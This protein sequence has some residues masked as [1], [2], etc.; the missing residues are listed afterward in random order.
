[1]TTSTTAGSRFSSYGD[2][3]GG[4]HNLLHGVPGAR[5]VGGWSA[6]LSSIKNPENEAEVPAPG[7]R[8]QHGEAEKAKMAPQPSAPSGLE[9]DSKGNAILF[10]ERTPEDQEKAQG[11]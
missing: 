8:L 4:L 6:T 11:S 7:P 9:Q 10:E 2:A 3:S 5:A 1:M